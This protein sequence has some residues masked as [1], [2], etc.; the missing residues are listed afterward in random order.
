MYKETIFEVANEFH[1]NGG[2]S[3]SAP[4][5]FLMRNGIKVERII[6]FTDEEEWVGSSFIDEFYEYKTQVSPTCKA[7]LVKL[8]PS[9]TN[10]AP[11]NITDVYFIY[12]WSENVLRYVTSDLESQMDEV[13]KIVL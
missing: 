12:G 5:T 11:P 10:I 8:V 4:V 3:L 9:R 13:R 6:A 7:Y 1:A 2:T